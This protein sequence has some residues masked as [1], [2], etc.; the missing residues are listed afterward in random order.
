MVCQEYTYP[1]N[2]VKLRFL[3]NH[4]QSRAAFLIPDPVSC[5]NWTAFTFF[6][7]GLP[8][9]YAG[10]EYGADHLP[11]LFD[12]DDVFIGKDGKRGLCLKGYRIETAPTEDGVTATAYEQDNIGSTL[13]IPLIQKLAEIKRDPIFTDSVYHVKAHAESVLIATHEKDGKKALGVFPVGAHKGY[14]EVDFPDGMYT[15]LIDGEPVDV[16]R[17]GLKAG[18]F[19]IILMTE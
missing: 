15:N 13:L 6:Q 16:F 8:L 10:Q 7:K 9:I 5:V 14:V 12:K 4:D 3:E 18:V 17:G 11:S 2:Y 19:P 1:E